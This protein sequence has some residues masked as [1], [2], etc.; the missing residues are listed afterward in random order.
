MLNQKMSEVL[1]SA[2]SSQE[3][4]DGHMLFDWRIGVTKD[5]FGQAP[6]LANLSARQAQEMG[7]LTSV[8]YG[9]HFLS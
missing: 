4:E 3:S 9:P 2:I 7:L 5:L 1:P 8:T 6:V